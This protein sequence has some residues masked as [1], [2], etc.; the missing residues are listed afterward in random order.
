VS[1]L[2]VLSEIEQCAS[3][4]ERVERTAWFFEECFVELAVLY[5]FEVVVV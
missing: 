2:S 1:T 5:S 3:K 4:V